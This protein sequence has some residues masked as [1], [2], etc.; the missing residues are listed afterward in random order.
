M[1]A[2]TA[3]DNDRERPSNREKMNKHHEKHPET[4]GKAKGEKPKEKTIDEHSE[5]W[6]TRTGENN[7]HVKD[8]TK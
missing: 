1:G 6:C 3:R 4:K 2:K 8:S 5:N 7:E